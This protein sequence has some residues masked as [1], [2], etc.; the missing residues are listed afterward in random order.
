LPN[1]PIQ[2]DKHNS[3]VVS[4]DLDLISLYNAGRMV[5]N[6][7][8]SNEKDVEITNDEPS[9]EDIEIEDIEA[10][11]S[12]KLKQVKEK[13]KRCDEEKRQALEDLQRAKAEFLNVRK[14]LEN[15]R[16]KDRLRAKL[17]HAEE[18]LPLCDSFEMAMSDKSAWEKADESW[19]KGV[20]G[21]HQQLQKLLQRYHVSTIE[22][23]GKSFDPHTMEALDTK[24][25][26]DE[27]QVDVVQSVLQTGYQMK[28]ADTIEIIRPARVVTGTLGVK[29]D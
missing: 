3:V 14:R 6:N 22:A 17:Q 26:E 23:D 27:K 4:F 12:D 2:T 7:E 20:E 19:R 15:D 13:L 9:A 16:E 10:I 11:S 25:V 18:L 5:K 1:T 28:Q 21:I 24:E 8:D 29:K